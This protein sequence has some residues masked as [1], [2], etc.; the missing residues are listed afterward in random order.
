MKQRLITGLSMFAFGLL[1]IYFG[2]TVFAVSSIVCFVFALY[3]EFHALS[4][5]G[6]RPVSWPTWLAMTVSIPLGLIFGSQTVLP[7]LVAATFLI[8]A[9]VLFRKNP[10]LEDVLMSV[11]PLL[12]VVLPGLCIISLTTIE[13]LSVQRVYLALLVVVPVGC[14]S[15][16]Y[17]AGKRFG[18][19]PF[20][21]EV[22]PKKTVEGAIGGMVGAMTGAMLVSIFARVLCGPA[23]QPLLPSWLQMVAMG[24][25]G[26][27]VSQGGDLF[28]SLIKRHCGVKDFSN[29]FPGHGGMLDR[30]D[31][32]L[33]MSVVV[34]CFRIVTA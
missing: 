7:V 13:P 18:K 19:T 12:S 24:L 30:L 14:D 31:S 33:F 16:A 8:T 3:E 29:L 10:E 15:F 20:C 5:A 32:I 28:A 6:H 27:A 23:T 17:F 25:V 4:A 2:G 9:S 34:F 1:I 11:T 21:P 22:S 26:G